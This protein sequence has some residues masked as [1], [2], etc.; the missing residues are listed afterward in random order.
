MPRSG[1]SPPSGS[2]GGELR[3]ARGSSG[4]SVVS[5]KVNE[6]TPLQKGRRRTIDSGEVS[7][8]SRYWR[9]EDGVQ[10]SSAIATVCNLV[11]DLCPAGLLPLPMCLLETGVVPAVLL[12]MVFAGACVWM[13]NLVGRTVVLTGKNTFASMWAEVIGPR[14]QWFPLLVLLG[15]T[16]GCSLGYVCLF[17][18][19]MVDLLPE[20]IVPAWGSTRIWTLA[21]VTPPLLPLCMVKDLSALSLVSGPAGLATLYAAGVIIFRSLDGS[22]MEGGR[23]HHGGAPTPPPFHDDP[24]RMSLK[25]LQ[26][27]N[28]LAVGYLCHYN[29]CKYYRELRGTTP[30][31]FTQV[32]GAGVGIT[33]FIFAAVMVFGFSTFGMG[34]KPV[35]LRSYHVEDGFARGARL[36]LAVAILG[37]LPLMFTGLREA[38]LEL[39]KLLCSQETAHELDRRV[40]QDLVSAALLITLML[41]SMACNDVWIVL[42]VVGAVCGSTTIYVLPC[43]LYAKSVGRVLGVE[44]SRVELAAVYGMLCFGVVLGISGLYVSVVP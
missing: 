25:S 4:S 15:V 20:E 9:L 5:R 31:R 11:V 39:M 13:M 21:A 36:L 27:V 18:E 3:I 35:I 43:L 24:F 19:M 16:F 42:N 22:Y 29:A 17:A 23:Y 6:L 1:S 34:T 41:V 14:T 12:A 2:S 44:R 30:R 32:V 10:T 33:S 7:R 40:V 8:S 37:S 26:L 28:T 38:A